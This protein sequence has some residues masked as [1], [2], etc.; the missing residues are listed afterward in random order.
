VAFRLYSKYLTVEKDQGNVSQICS[1]QVWVPIQR[2]TLNS[3]RWVMYDNV[4]GDVTSVTENVTEDVTFLPWLRGE[5]NG[6]FMEENCAILKLE[7]RAYVDMHCK[8]SYCFHCRF[9]YDNDAIFKLR[10]L[11]QEQVSILPTFYEQLFCVQIQKAKR[12]R[13]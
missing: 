12:E 13:H 8:M 9:D 4:K 2:S 7:S 1:S 11:C 6:E 3:S 10:G 5:P